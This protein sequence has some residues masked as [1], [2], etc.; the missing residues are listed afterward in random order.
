[1][2]AKGSFSKSNEIRLVR[3]YDAPLKT[4]WEAWTDPAKA[5][6]WWGPRGF[7]LTTHSKELKPGGIW[8]YT[9]HEPDGTDYPNKARYLEVEKYAR[10]VYDH[11]GYDDR[12]PLVRVTVLFSEEKG[13]TRMDMTM[14]L[15]TAEAAEQ[16]RKFIKKANGDSTWDRFAEYLEHEA[17]GREIFVIH[18]SFDAPIEKVFEAWTDPKQVA[19]WM[20]PSGFEME[21]LRADE[22][23]SRHPGAP[24]WPETMLTTVAFTEEAAGRT[25]VRIQ[26]EAHRQVAPAELAAFVKERGGMTGGWTGSLDKLE[27]YLG[28]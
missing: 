18:R 15:P 12:A 2:A 10:L 26:W 7:T 24:T 25:R 27:A 6:K 1:V 13:K 9:M 21:Y 23:V 17:S 28:G 11:G 19:R 3:V 22:K 4:V 5:A 14:A 16:T 20:P 8:H